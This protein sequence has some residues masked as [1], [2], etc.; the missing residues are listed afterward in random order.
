MALVRVTDTGIGMKPEDLPKLF[1]Q[2]RQVDGS[3]TR[4][5]GGTGLG[6][7]ITRHLVWMHEGD[8]HV[9]S[10]FGVGSTFWFTLPLF[11]AEAVQ[12]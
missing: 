10:T 5:A 4:R 7:H 11:V 1:E 3:S 12:Q 9:E 6:L 2:F 8:I